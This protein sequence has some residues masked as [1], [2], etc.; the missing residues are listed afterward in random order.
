M[1]PVSFGIPQGSVLGPTLLTNDLP[2]SVKS[3][4]VYMYADDT[5]VFCQDHTADE[6]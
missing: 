1:L 5:A 3:G 4:S 6:E 2:A